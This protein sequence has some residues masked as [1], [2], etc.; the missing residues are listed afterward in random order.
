MQGP[1][2]AGGSIDS[3]APCSWSGEQ[4]HVLGGPEDE[5]VGQQGVAPEGEAVPARRGQDDCGDLR[6][7]LVPAVM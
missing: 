7:L 1:V 2:V 6:V 3:D 4:V 5:P